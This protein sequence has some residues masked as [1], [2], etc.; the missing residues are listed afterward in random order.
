LVNP[1]LSSQPLFGPLQFL[2]MSC[3]QALAGGLN[4]LT[5]QQGWARTLLSAHSG[6]T[7]RLCFAEKQFN[8]T[9]ESTGTFTAAD[10]AVVPD[11]TVALVA[12][13]FSLGEFFSAV[14]RVELA[15]YFNV[16]GEASFAQTLSLLARDL[17]P[18]PEDALAQWLGDIPA[19]RATQVAVA[20]S[21]GAVEASKRVAHNL[22]EYLT[23]ETTT[24]ADAISQ[25]AFK[26]NLATVQAGVA[27]VSRRLQDLS[28]RLEQLARGR[29][30][31]V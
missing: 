29:G 13:R 5:R 24:L 8:L 15:K 6:K 7:L 4:L 14:P 9:V 18:E 26:T 11:V 25:G 12:E 17:R 22:S 23:Y 1:I 27:G 20:A 31:Q 3:A 21:R 30:R 16:A 28:V 19:R 2:A 10:D